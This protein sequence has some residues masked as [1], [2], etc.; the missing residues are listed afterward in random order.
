MTGAEADARAT[1]GRCAHYAT[2]V[3]LRS[4]ARDAIQYA[5][6]KDGCDRRPRR[7]ATGVAAI[8]TQTR[9]QC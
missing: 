5:R 8:R 9:G 7:P 4:L 1:R 2:V 3:L 6:E